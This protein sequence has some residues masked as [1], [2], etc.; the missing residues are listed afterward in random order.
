MPYLLV[1]RMQKQ[2]RLLPWA[3]HLLGRLLAQ[4]GLAA[5]QQPA[6]LRPPLQLLLPVLTQAQG[7]LHPGVEQLQMWVDI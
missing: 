2:A 6:L 4:H 7:L 1:L 3:Q 5:A